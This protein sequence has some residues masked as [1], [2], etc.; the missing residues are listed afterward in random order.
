MFMGLTLANI[1]GFRQRPGWVKPSA[2]GC[3]FWQRGAGSDFNG[4]SVLLIT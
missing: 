1:G 4:K 3:H 2:G